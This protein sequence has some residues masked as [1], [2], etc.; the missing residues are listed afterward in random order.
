MQIE[1]TVRRLLLSLISQQM[2]SADK[3]VEKGNP[4]AATMENTM[5]IPQ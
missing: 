3:D 2:T 4:C 1:T 5:E